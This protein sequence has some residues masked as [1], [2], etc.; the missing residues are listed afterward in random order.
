MQDS[1]PASDGVSL[2]AFPGGTD[3]VLVSVCQLRENYFGKRVCG[4]KTIFTACKVLERHFEL[5]PRGGVVHPPK[6]HDEARFV[7]GLRCAGVVQGLQ[8][9][10]SIVP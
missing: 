7:D 1:C 8:P 4:L 3:Q 9:W 5:G 10:K 6:R 2:N